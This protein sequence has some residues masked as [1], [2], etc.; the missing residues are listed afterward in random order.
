M[1][2]ASTPMSHTHL[3]LTGIRVI[4]LAPLYPG[5]LATMMLADLGADVIQVENPN[6]GDR[7]RR[8]PGHFEALNRNKR[9]V[10][11]DLKAADQRELFLKLVETADV[12]IEG[13]R[14]GVM[15]R[16][17]L[18]PDV[19]RERKPD[20]I[21][22]S[23]SSYGQDGPMSQ[24]GG[25]D[26]SLQAAAGLIDVRPGTESDTALPRLAIS[27][28]ASGNA[29]AFGVV[30]A[31]L[32]RERVGHA[33]T[34]DVSM[35]DSVVTWMAPYLVPVMNGLQG[36]RLPP[37]DPAY[38][39]F[40]SQDRVQFSLSISGEDHLWDVLCTELG[41]D[42]LVGLKEH[43]RIA[44][45]SRIQDT[46]RM[47]LASRSMSWLED[48]FS[49]SKIPFGP[50]RALSE[51][52]DDPQVQAR[53]MV[54]EFIDAAGKKMRYVRQAVVFD[55]KRTGVHSRAPQLGEHTAELL[56]EIGAEAPV[57]DQL[58]RIGS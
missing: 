16:L 57:V 56:Q 43:D 23:I 7:T 45:R 44:D 36:A 41:M 38:G 9:S 20:L 15:A 46:L 17:K 52:Q 31:L 49:Q 22:A 30:C 1:S 54:V 18:T 25:H 39:I 11:L 28:I 35:L 50:V 26:L 4:S 33:S 48:M 2:F 8:F 14:P 27:D 51:I 55:G 5:P 19:L 3:P 21:F 6:G 34:L 32:Q 24:H 10:A 58:S 12:V 13:F 29:A 47:V 42:A 37:T 53:G 40:I